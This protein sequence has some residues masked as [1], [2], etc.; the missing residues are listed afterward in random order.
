LGE[1]SCQAMVHL[2]GDEYE[3]ECTL[4]PGHPKPHR[5]ELGYEWTDDEP[6]D[7]SW[8]KDRG[9]PEPHLQP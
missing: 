7:G 4:P 3:G 6:Y 1:M 2:W 9:E 8:P 5:D